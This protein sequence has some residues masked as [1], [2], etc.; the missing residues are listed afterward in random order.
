MK[1]AESKIKKHG[2][3]EQGEVIIYQ[4]N[5][6]QAMLDVHLTEETVWL[7]QRQMTALFDRNKRT[8]SEHVRN[9]FKEGELDEDA[10][11][12]NF[13]TT[14]GD[15]KAYVTNYYNLDVVISVGYRVKSQRGTQ[16]RI[17]A[18]NVLKQH[19]VQGYTT[20]ERR[21]AEKGLVEMEQTIALLARTLERHEELTDEGRAVLEVISRYAKTWSLLLQYDEDR[22][23]LPKDRQST[24][25]SL[26]YQQ[27][28]TAIA[29]LKA[30]LQ[31][32][33]ESG[34]LFGQ[35]REQHLKGILGNLDQTFGGHDLYASVEEKAA[36]LL[37][38]VIKDHPFGDGNKRI[39]A[40]LFV[41]FLR[42]NN[43]L[44][45]ARLNDNG[46]VALALLIAES[47]P[48]QK[49]LLVRLVINLLKFDSSR[50]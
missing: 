40:F 19:L 28:K 36:H 20:N 3:P 15:G 14:A 9:V 37:Y 41:L 47:D 49:E 32:R 34:D 13:R 10:V 38:F 6:G 16:F 35:E 29:A 26:D 33:G 23:E 30:E 27:V 46:L 8:I 50:Q 5:D 24:G 2:Q 18:T 7:T 48:K 39:G 45:Q 43:L 17:W 22:L 42:E 4:S 25:K 21:L 44:D 12:R 1:N 11:V 31:E